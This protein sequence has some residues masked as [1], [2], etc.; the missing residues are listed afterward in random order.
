MRILILPLALILGACLH[1]LLPALAALARKADDAAQPTATSPGFSYSA[2][3]VSR[4]YGF[5]LNLL[6]QRLRSNE[7]LVLLVFLLLLGGCATLL[8]AIHPLVCA[9]VMA[10]LFTAFSC[11]PGCAKIKDALDS[12][13][14]VNDIPAYE[15]LVRETCASLAPAFSRGLVLPLLL[16]APGMPLHLGCASGYIGSALVML[17]CSRPCAQRAAGFLLRVSDAVL[18]ALLALCSGVTGRA[19]TRV[20]GRDTHTRLLSTLGIAG[21]PTDT[22]AP[23]AGD[24]AQGIFLCCFCSALLCLML[25]AAFFVLC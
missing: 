15:A 16:C 14:Y 5:V 21:E 4:L 17:A 1:L 2:D 25:C 24:I 11:L 22:H 6:P 7:R 9:F 10:P 20:R 18:I 19:P 23:M 12:G 13:R 3:A 8:G